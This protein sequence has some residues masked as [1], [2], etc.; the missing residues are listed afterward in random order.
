MKGLRA[1]VLERELDAT[2][3]E[4]PEPAQGVDAPEAL[5]LD[6]F[7]A[8]C[9]ADPGIIADPFPPGL[10]V[11]NDS[12]RATGLPAPCPEDEL[13]ALSTLAQMW[14]CAEELALALRI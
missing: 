4:V 9:V 2:G 1:G 5:R 13:A 12:R 3:V 7:K 6:C 14:L 11:G 8:A 10:S